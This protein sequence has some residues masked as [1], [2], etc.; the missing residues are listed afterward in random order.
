METKKLEFEDAQV[1]HKLNP[2]TF[3]APTQQE[4]DALK[5]E[6]CVKVCVKLPKKKNQPCGERFWVKV[7][8]IEG[9]EVIGEVY[10]EL[11]YVDIQHGE[12]ITFKKQ[13][14]YSIL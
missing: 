8:L 11:I 7:K 3:E 5:P 4:L 10:N 14:I 6:D 1:L 12:P 9:D 13:N 2:T